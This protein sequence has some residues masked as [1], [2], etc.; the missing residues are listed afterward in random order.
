MAKIILQN[1]REHDI[2]I[3][4]MSASGEVAQVTVPAARQSQDDKNVLING[5]AEADDAVV[6]AAK[7]SPVVA[8]YFEEGW[9]Q[10][11][12]TDKKASKAPAKGGNQE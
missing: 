4:A 10:I 12:T 3:N 9:L 2:T 8:H 6:E 7:K 11:A 5:Q 1:T